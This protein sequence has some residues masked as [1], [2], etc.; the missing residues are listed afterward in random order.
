MINTDKYTLVL[1]EVEKL[2][3]ENEM[4]K[5]TVQELSVTNEHLVSA[6]W[7]E[8]EMKQELSKIKE[9]LEYRNAKIN[10]SI[11]YAKNIQQ[12]MISN[13]SRLNAS[14][15]N[16]MVFYKPKD[17]VSG[18]FPW[19]YVND[20]YVYFAAVDCTGHGVPGAMLA[21]VGNILLDNMCS[22]FD[23]DT[24]V[25]LE[26]LHEK[27]VRVLKQ[28]STDTNLNDGLD[29][30]I[31]KYCKKSRKIQFSGAHRPIVIVKNNGDFIEVKGDRQAIGGVQGRKPRKP[32]SMHEFEVSDGDKIFLFSDGYQDQF[33]A[34]DKVKY[35]IKRL[36]IL[37]SQTKGKSIE[38][39]K[40]I[41]QGDWN[42]WIGNGVQI[43]DVLL[44][45]VEL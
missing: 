20:D 36:R 18:D 37:L 19:S 38:E 31:C 22:S 24:S 34:V 30:A 6:T 7:R 44:I 39:F 32:F 27:V 28:N 16:S 25:V 13:E 23:Y 4:L 14:F 12:S 8:R 11:N 9:A 15:R 5:N 45:G 33:G 35:G 21:I 10:E 26:V 43:D 3:A 40:Q 29:I 1:E 17:L 41:V 2:K 42:K